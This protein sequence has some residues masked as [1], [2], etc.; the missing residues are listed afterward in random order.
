MR[1]VRHPLFAALSSLKLTILLLSG[2]LLLV[3]FGTL[4]QVHLGIYHAQQ[5]YFETLLTAWPYP[6]Q[7]PLGAQ[8]QWLHLPLPGGYLIGP[9]LLVNLLCAHFRYYRAGWRKLGIVWIH[10]GIALL[11]VGQ[12]WT[13]LAQRD[14]FLWLQEGE[15]RHY[16]ES[17]HERELVVLEA[18][19][20]GRDRV[21]S[22]PAAGLAAGETTL[23]HAQLPFRIEIRNVYRNAAILRRDANPG[24]AAFPLPANRGVGREQALLAVPQPFDYAHNAQ[25]YKTAVVEL[26]DTAGGGESLGTWLLSDLFRPD[27]PAEVPIPAQSFTHADRS[28]ALQ[29]R[30]RRHYL[31]ADLQL[32]DFTHD[33]YPGTQVPYNFASAVLL[34]EDGRAEP[35]PALIYMNHPL[36]YAGLTF[37]QASFADQDTRSMLQVVENPARWVPYIACGLVTLGL[38]W[39]FTLGLLRAAQR[40]RGRRQLPATGAGPT[41]PAP[42][43]AAQPLPSP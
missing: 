1:T 21:H 32:V 5:K 17:F 39:Q 22:W 3:F 41:D 42:A 16:V 25:N 9:L 11:L 27:F 24:Y 20:Q 7:F 28:F 37:Y 6:E 30:H 29:L 38:L 10:L 18:L 13:Q 26:F 36:R 31:P 2:G 43:V 4:E 34:H 40:G 8:L 23:A 35:R 15:S 14:Y 12:L 19:D 33:R